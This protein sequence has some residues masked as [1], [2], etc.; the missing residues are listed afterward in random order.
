MHRH[1]TDR[2]SFKYPSGGLLQVTG[3]LSKE[4]IRKPTQLDANGE[5]CILAIKNGLASGVTVGRASGIE[6][7]VRVYGPE[8]KTWTS[9]EIAV[10]PYS[11]KDGAFSAPGDSGSIVVNWEGRIIGQLNGG[12]GTTDST[13]V[14]YLTPF[15]WLLEQIKKAFPD[16]FL[17]QIKV[18]VA[19]SGTLARRLDLFDLFHV[20]LDRRH[21]LPVRLHSFTSQFVVGANVMDF[22][23][24]SSRLCLTHIETLCQLIVLRCLLISGSMVTSIGERY[25]HSLVL[26]SLVKIPT[27]NCRYWLA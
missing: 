19:T 23:Y 1:A 25:Y 24:R 5:K 18:Q 2:S 12:A 4:E 13:D 20:L 7:F 11:Q 15:H 26:R 27:S 6:S 16:A 3:V 17:Y 22:C 10:Y 9:R 21:A 14:T 8:G